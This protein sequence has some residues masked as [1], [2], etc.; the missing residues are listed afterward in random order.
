MPAELKRALALPDDLDDLHNCVT[1][2]QQQTDLERAIAICD[3]WQKLS[4]GSPEVIEAMARD[5]AKRHGINP[6]AELTAAG[7]KAMERHRQEASAALA[8]GMKKV[9]EGK[10]WIRRSKCQ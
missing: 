8:A 2:D 7:L 10:R 4:A 5:T 1:S 9:M 3:A 6:D